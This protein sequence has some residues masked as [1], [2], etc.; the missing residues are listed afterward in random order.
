ME[1][2]RTLLMNRNSGEVVNLGSPSDTIRMECKLVHGNARLPKR[3]KPT[4]AGYDISSVE[5]LTIAPGATAKV[6]TGIELSAPAGYYWTMEGRSSLNEARVFVVRPIMDATFCGPAFVYLRNEGL[7]D[8]KI[9]VGDRI[10]QILLHR[11]LSME[12]R[13][14]APDEEFSPEYNQ[15]GRSGFGSTGR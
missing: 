1:S 2:G 9:E 4:D 3:G 5:E 6:E 13:Q 12:I 15:R 8:Y 11:V 14:L 7:S 10:A